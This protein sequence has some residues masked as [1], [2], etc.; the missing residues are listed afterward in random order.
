MP[1]AVSVDLVTGRAKAACCTT[2]VRQD[3]GSMFSW[4]YREVQAERI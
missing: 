4:T 1:K 2:N 3:F